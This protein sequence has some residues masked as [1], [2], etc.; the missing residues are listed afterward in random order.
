MQRTFRWLYYSKRQKEVA[1]GLIIGSSASLGV[2]AW[3]FRRPLRADSGSVADSKS[4][5]SKTTKISNNASR[6]RRPGNLDNTQS[7]PPQTKGHSPFEKE[8]DSSEV[9]AST[10]QNLTNRVSTVS[11]S[12]TGWDFEEVRS[13]IT[14]SIVPEWIRVL[15]FYIHKIQDEVS[16]SPQS[17]GWE[18]WEN[19]HD[20]ECKSFAADF[21]PPLFT[22][23]E[24]H[25]QETLLNLF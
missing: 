15:P 6:S 20:P 9:S 22:E 18:C 17:L 23:Q 21:F 11:D 4:W 8:D 16:G 5:S 3:H 19:A 12:F 7:P 14:N 2:G 25:L 24:K 10:W 1:L 13:K